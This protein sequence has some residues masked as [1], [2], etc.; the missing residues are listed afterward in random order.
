MAGN[1]PLAHFLGS[2]VPLTSLAI[3]QFD[4]QAGGDYVWQEHAEIVDAVER[5]DAVMAEMLMSRRLDHLEERL[6]N[7]GSSTIRT[8]AAG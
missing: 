3:A 6:L 7:A 1:A 4:A 5:E 2:L 8:R